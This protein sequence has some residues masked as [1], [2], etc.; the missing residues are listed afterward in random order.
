MNRPS[1]VH[2]K[3][4][5]KRAVERQLRGRNRRGGKVKKTIKAWAGFCDG[6]IST[7]RIAGESNDHVFSVYKTRKDAKYEANGVSRYADLR[8]V[9]ISFDNEEPEAK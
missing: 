1:H 3:D 8:R 6:K 9:E 5:I 4:S 7:E 2:E